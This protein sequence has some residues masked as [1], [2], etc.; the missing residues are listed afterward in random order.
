MALANLWILVLVGVLLRNAGP[1]LILYRDLTP[2]TPCRNTLRFANASRG[3]GA[4]C[5]GWLFFGGGDWEGGG[6]VKTPAV[7]GCAHGVVMG[8]RPIIAWHELGSSPRLA[9][10][11]ATLSA[12]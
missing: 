9:K 6:N 11:N 7:S 2:N 5:D 1:V 4:C 12:G 8:G 3:P 10:M